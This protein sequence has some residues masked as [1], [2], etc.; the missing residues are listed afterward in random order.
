MNTIAFPC[1]DYID[2]MGNPTGF[3]S[4]QDKVRKFRDSPFL[5]RVG[6]ARH[7]FYWTSRIPVGPRVSESIRGVI[8][9]LHKRPIS[10]ETVELV[11][12]ICRKNIRQQHTPENDTQPKQAP[13][14]PEWEKATG[15]IHWACSP[16]AY[17]VFRYENGVRII[18]EGDSAQKHFQH[19]PQNSGELD[20]G[21]R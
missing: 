10:M 11:N 16:E 2:S 17:E 3:Q 18:S 8:A 1:S 9:F 12:T 20:P 6:V 4:F 15:R 19:T 21:K 7:P 14:N 13:V 5:A